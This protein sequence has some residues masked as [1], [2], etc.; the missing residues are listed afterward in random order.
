MVLIVAFLDDESEID[1][2]SP[3]LEAND[4]LVDGYNGLTE[5]MSRKETRIIRNQ[6]IR[7][8]LCLET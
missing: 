3:A 2:D 5:M 7:K 1:E 6:V 4:E 8:Y